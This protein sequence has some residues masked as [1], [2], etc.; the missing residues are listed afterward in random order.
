MVSP[1][2]ITAIDDDDDD[3]SDASSV[4]IDNDLDR[5]YFLREDSRRTTTPF[6]P[7]PETVDLTDPDGDYVADECFEILH[8]DWVRSASAARSPEQP[9][10]PQRRRLEEV[11][12]DDGIVY[13]LGQSVELHDNTFLRISSIWEESREIFLQGRRLLKVRYHV[14]NYLPRWHN[15]LIWIANETTDIPLAIVQRFVAIHFTNHCH[16]S[17]DPQKKARP[18]N[19]FCRLKGVLNTS[20]EFLTDTEADSDFCLK[21]I[22]LRRSWRGEVSSFGS[23]RRHQTPVVVLDETEDTQQQKY[24][25]GDGFC[26]AGGVSCGAEAAGLQ[27]KWAFDLSSRAAATYRLNFPTAECEESDIFSFLTNDEEFL[28]VDVTHGSPP[29]QTF[30]PAH[31]IASAN[32]DANSACIFS[33][34]DIIRKARPRVHTMEETSGLLERH[35]ATLDRVILDFIEIGYSVRWALLKCMEY[36]VPQIR[37]RLIIIAS[38]PGETLPP[39]PRPTHGLPGSGLRNLVTINQA[40]SNIPPGALD[41]DIEGALSRGSQNW[42]VPFDGNQQA[43]TVTCGGGDSNYNYHPS[44]Q[45]PFTYREYACL[46][47][48][49]L[50]FRFGPLEVLKQIGNAVPPLLAKAVYEGIIRS[51]RETDER[52]LRE[53]KR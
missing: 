33:C 49:P 35:R 42:K 17:H 51:L 36:G 40:I 38:G 30:S 20:V 22:A 53:S 32:D 44:G 12:G 9:E 7:L 13:M 1:D 47:T 23:V 16:P 39:L 14:G 43:R 2:P 19:L 24:T 15:E 11:T 37:K 27:I 46:Q 50:S 48:F 4:T 3:P 8:E 28:R 5:P 10:L 29:C 25:F 21:P 18:N 34:A 31:T 52:E 6:L 45:R 41:H 26:G